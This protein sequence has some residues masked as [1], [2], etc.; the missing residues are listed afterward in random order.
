M[1][2]DAG[3]TEARWTFLGT[4]VTYDLIRGETSALAEDA[5]SVD[6]GLTTCLAGGHLTVRWS[7]DATVPAPSQQLFYVVRVAG[8]AHFGRSSLLKPREATTPCP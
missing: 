5:S 8:E 1:G 4:G 7:C 2:H 6:L 3:C